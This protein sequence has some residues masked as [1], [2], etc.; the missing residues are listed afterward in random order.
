MATTKARVEE[1]E[2]MVEHLQER[3]DRL[4]DFTCGEMF[5]ELVERRVDAILAK[6]H[7]DSIICDVALEDRL[8]ELEKQISKFE[9]K[10]PTLPY[11][12]GCQVREYINDKVE[13]EV[14]EKSHANLIAIIN[15]I[16]A[17]SDM[18]KGKSKKVK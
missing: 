4:R 16:S 17:L 1:L 18:P 2:A 11:K 6:Y 14:D 3:V 10:M 15:F 9:K 13:R 7:L 8:S 12:Y 5:D